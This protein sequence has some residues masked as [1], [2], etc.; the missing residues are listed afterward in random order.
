MC[1]HSNHPKHGMGQCHG[2]FSNN[3]L[4]WSKKKKKE[5][6]EHYRECLRNQLEDVEEAIKEIEEDK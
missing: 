1:C 5:M 3:P 2:H 4:L 6:L